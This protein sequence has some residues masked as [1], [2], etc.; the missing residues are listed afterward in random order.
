MQVFGVHHVSLNTPDVEATA[1]FY[2]AHLGGIRRNDRPELGFDGAWIDL[3]GQQVHLLAGQAP[4]ALGQHF[5]L[6][7]ADL[8]AAVGELR[9]H[10]VEVSDPV[11][12]G[13]ARQ[14][15]LHDPAGNLVELHQTARA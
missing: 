15:F 9:S 2:I 11:S 1:A 10:G 12:I 4:P 3:G 7:V 5:A 8:D 14:S 6:R 13:D